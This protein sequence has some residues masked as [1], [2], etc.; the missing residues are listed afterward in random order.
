MKHEEVLHK[1]EMNMLYT[2][3]IWEANWIGHILRRNRLLK[4]II[5][6]KVRGKDKSDGKT[7]NKKY[8]ATRW[9]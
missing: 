6:G 1:E 2:I 4:H 8:A 9:P 5:E 7:K 3:K